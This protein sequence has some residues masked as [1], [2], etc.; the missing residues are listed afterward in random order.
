MESAW[1]TRLRAALDESGLSM[2]AASLAAGKAHGYLN[3]ILNEGKDPTITNLEDVCRVL[4]VPV[5]RVLYGLD[6]PEL[7]EFVDL[8][9]DAPPRRRRLARDILD[10][11]DKAP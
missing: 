8:L 7:Q 5:V 1:R 2:R 11:E 6:A 9:K 3:S 4:H 10:S